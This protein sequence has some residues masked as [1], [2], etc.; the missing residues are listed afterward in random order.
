MTLNNIRRLLKELHGIGAVQEIDSGCWIRVHNEA[1]SVKAEKK[2]ERR[3]IKTASMIA[4][5]ESSSSEEEAASNER[6][7]GS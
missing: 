4:R 1:A 7:H 3:T 5:G 2:E 6:K